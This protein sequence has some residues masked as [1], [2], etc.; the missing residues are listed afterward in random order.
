M[1]VTGLSFGMLKERAFSGWDMGQ[2]FSL[3]TGMQL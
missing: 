1:A 2:D 3:E